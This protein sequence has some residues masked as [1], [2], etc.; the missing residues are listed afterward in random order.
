MY[1]FSA[2][3]ETAFAEPTFIVTIIE[4]VSCISRLNWRPT[5]K[6]TRVAK[7]NRNSHLILA[8]KAG[9]LTTVDNRT[10]LQ[11]FQ[12]VPDCSQNAVPVCE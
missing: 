6:A 5:L 10:L 2:L 11:P 9:Y 7:Y 3:F 4:A 8:T 12:V 1:S